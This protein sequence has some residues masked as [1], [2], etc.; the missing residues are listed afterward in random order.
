MTAINYCV[1][2]KRLWKGGKQ[3]SELYCTAGAVLQ[4]VVRFCFTFIAKLPL[5]S[6]FTQ[7]A[8]NDYYIAKELTE[9]TEIYY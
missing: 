2:R 1:G 3:F 6:K 8:H 9:E 4:Q 7:E 5:G